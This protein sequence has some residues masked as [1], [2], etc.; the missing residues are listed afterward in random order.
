MKQ[1]LLMTLALGCLTV[2]PLRAHPSYCVMPE[3][4]ESFKRSRA[5]FLGQAVEIV[6]PKTSDENAP[7]T[8]RAFT[9]RFKIVQSWKGVP[10]AAAEFKILWLH[11]CYECLDLP[12]VNDR[13]LVY[14][15]AVPDNETWSIVTACNR[16]TVVG[17]PRI[18]HP[19]NDVVD[20]YR[21]M[22]Q[23]DIITQRAFSIESPR[24]RPRIKSLDRRAGHV[25]RK[26]ID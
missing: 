11:R 21:D 18:G 9:V 26:L 12:H 16:S 24:F 13:Y 5:V 7:F 22:K 20:P 1:I 15:D 10:S 8:D 3:L 2:C 23:L 14:A 6:A 25:F 19:T 17:D 4:S